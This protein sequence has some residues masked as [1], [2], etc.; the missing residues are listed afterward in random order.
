M[1]LTL[2]LACGGEQQF[3][4]NNTNGVGEQGVAELVYSPLEFT[5]T[6]LNWEDN[7]SKSAELT[8]T[9]SGDGNL[10]LSVVDI[11]D[12]GGGAFY[13]TEETN[14]IIAPESERSFTVVAT[15]TEFVAAEGELRVKSNDADY[16]DLRIPLY[17]TPAG[18]TGDT[19]GGD[20]TGDT[21]K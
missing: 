13:T 19:T 3:T 21:G 8:I 18:W 5:F 9:N 4:N 14:L 7:V 2:M 16:L 15:L 1:I 17:A 6:D 12:S 20:D 10:S 11:S